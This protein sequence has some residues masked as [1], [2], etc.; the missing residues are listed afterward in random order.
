MLNVVEIVEINIIYKLANE[1]D[2]IWQFSPD[3]MNFE[4][5]VYLYVVA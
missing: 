2:L 3:V 5:R 4:V 1:Y